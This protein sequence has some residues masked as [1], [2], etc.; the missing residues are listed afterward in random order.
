MLGLVWNCKMEKAG[1]AVVV[2]RAYDFLFIS[3]FVSLVA[4][5]FLSLYP[6]WFWGCHVCVAA[7]EG[8]AVLMCSPFILLMHLL[9]FINLRIF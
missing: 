4:L 9:L 6:V 8:C 1:V 5:F 3:A 2:N 7:W